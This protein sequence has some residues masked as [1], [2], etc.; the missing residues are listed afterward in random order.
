[1]DPLPTALAAGKVPQDTRA[2]VVLVAKDTS[3]RFAVDRATLVRFAVVPRNLL[4]GADD[5]EELPLENEHCTE[6]TVAA[7]ALWL[8]HHRPAGVPVTRIDYPIAEGPLAQC[9]DE[10]DLRFIEAHLVPGG[11]MTKTAAL[12]YLAGTACYLDIPILREMCCGYLSWH[13]RQAA[14]DAKGIDGAPTA[15]AVVRSWFGKPDVTPEER[16]QVLRDHT[17]ARDY[18][19][20]ELEKQGGDAHAF[21][22]ENAPPPS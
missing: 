19:Y 16:N 21:A 4:D 15:T 7:L 11:D 22:A 6:A 17:W 8:E 3:A 12:Y 5:T 2:Q 13:V 10:W 14:I 1:M 18:D 9:F 20:K